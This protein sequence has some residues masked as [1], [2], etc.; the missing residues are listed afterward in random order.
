MIPSNEYAARRQRILSVMEEDS[1]MVLFSG[2]EKMSSAD[3]TYP[4][5]VNRN[6]YYLTGIDQ[7]DSSLILVNTDGE[8]RE[9]LFVSPF[10][11]VK[12]K[13]YG[14]R[15]TLQE[16]AKISGVSNAQVNTIVMDKVAGI[17]DPTLAQYGEVSHIYLDLEPEIKIAE[18][19]TTR[20]YR[21]TIKHTFPNVEVL[22]AYPLI[23]TL[24]LRKSNKEIEELRSAI[25]TTKLGVYSVMNAMKEGKREFEMAD[26]FLHT[27]NDDNCYQ[28]LAFPTIM[29]AGKNATCL[30]Y[31]TLQGVMHDGD[32]LLMDLGARNGYYCADVS[33]TVP[34]SGKF[35]KEQKE[36]YNIVLGANK[37]VAK[38]LKPGVTIEELQQAT[39]MYLA[40]ECLAKG[41]I[42]KKEDIMEYYYHGV[43]HLIGLDTHDAYFAPNSRESKKLK[44]EPGMIISNEPG[45][46]M[47][48]RGIGIRIED[49]LLVTEEGCEV[50]TAE[51]IK[52]ADDIEAYLAT[53]R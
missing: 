10:D 9:F 40:D 34:V 22:D 21:D 3:E 44:L 28:G 5:E 11:P 53:K 36:I 1:I 19:T 37:M 4:F 17:L 7:P 16:A 12:E 26:L 48:D 15:L 46:Y 24:R 38:M 31:R 25:R 42:K 14:R 52:E 35:T 30:H 41:Y 23:T 18:E 50:L 27:V 45:L 8:I 49:D 51:I 13:W 47:A 2:V 6:F 43:S 39:I 33:R 20:D 32:L 29:A